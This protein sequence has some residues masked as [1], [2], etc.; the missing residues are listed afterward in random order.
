MYVHM[1]VQVSMGTKEDTSYRVVLYNWDYRQLRATQ[2][3]CWELNSSPLQ[4][5]EGT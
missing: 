5:S 1:C 2:H 4:S 3:G